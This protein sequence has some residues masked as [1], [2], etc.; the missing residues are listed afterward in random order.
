MDRLNE[1]LDHELHEVPVPSRSASDVIASGTRRRRLRKA[2]T[3]GVASVVAMSSIVL[4]SR[5][6]DEPDGRLGGDP[7]F[8]ERILFNTLPWSEIPGQIFTVRPDGTDLEQITKPDADYL[9]PAVSPDGSRI[10]FV[11]F[12]MGSDPPRTG[13]EGIFVMNVGGSA[14]HEL[15]RTGEPKPISVSQIA[16]SPDGSQIGFIRNYFFD[17]S[18]ANFQHELWI[19]GADGS[20]PHELIDLQIDSFSWSPDGS[21]IVFTEQSVVGNRFRWDLHVMDAD[22]SNVQPL[23]DDGHSRYPAWSPVGDMVAFQR[24]IG[25]GAT[26]LY[27]LEPA[28]PDGD[29]RAVWTGDLGIDS[30]AWSPDSSRIVFDAYDQRQEHCSILTVTL[31]GEATSIL[32]SRRPEP[33]PGG[34]SEQSLCAGTVTWT[35]LVEAT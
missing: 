33:M 7:A 35:V 4:I 2:A 6:F 11:R 14:M 3:I 32:E 13:H 16:W 22:G 31:D 23:T 20:D 27:V 9:S 28:H 24:W 21:R 15:L 5:A 17:S 1:R 18:E 29:P 25:A 34:T 10:A 12:D 19:M 30:L 8:E 26:H